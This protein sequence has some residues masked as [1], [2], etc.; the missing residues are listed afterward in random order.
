M[1]SLQIS[2]FLK[3]AECM[4]FSGAAQ[5][6]YVTQPSVSRQIKLL[7]TELGY[8]LFDRTRKN[9]LRLTAEGIIFRDAFSQIQRQYTLAQDLARDLSGRSPMALRVGVGSGWDLSREL[10]QARREIEARFPQARIIFESQD[11]REL[12]RQIRDGES[13]VILCTKTSLM[14]FDGLEVAEIANLES[15]AYVRKGLLRPTGEDLTA[16]DFAGQ[17]LLMLT[18]SESP[19]AMELAL[20]QFQARQVTVFPRYMPNRESILQALLLGEGV[21][22]FDQYVRFSGDPRLDWFNLEDD[23]PICLVW[24]EGNRNPLIRLFADTLIRGME[25]PLSDPNS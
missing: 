4:S 8:P 7:E 13:D 25:E 15:R 14:D 3:T 20:L 11:F 10:T 9:A 12:R 21:T 2:Y 17:Q 22:V 19:M 23:I 16:S 24:N 6:L 18:E 1:T 5:A